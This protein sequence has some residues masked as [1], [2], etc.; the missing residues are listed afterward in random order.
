MDDIKF[1]LED[2]NISIDG[3]INLSD[4]EFKLTKTA[5]AKKKTIFKQKPKF[6]QRSSVQNQSRPTPILRQPTAPPPAFMDKTFEAFSNPQKRM[7]QQD[8]AVS[9]NA[10][11]N[12]DGES[13]AG[14]SAA[15][16][17]DFPQE[18][19]PD[20]TG[21]QPSAGFNSI[22]D[23][24][25]DLL[26]RFHRLES[27]GIKLPKKYNMYSDVREM[28]SDFERIKR[29][30][31]VNA[32]VKFSRRMLTA[33]VSASEFLNKRYDP[34]GL[35]LNGWSETVMENSTDG[36]YD[37]VFER[38]HDKYAGKVNTPPELELMLSL[39]GSAIMF[40]MTSTMFKSIPNLGAMA[41]NNPEMQQAMSNLAQN[42]M[43]QQTATTTTENEQET[44]SQSGRRK[45]RG[46]SM[47]LSSMG[48]MM[49]PPMPSSSFQQQTPNVP[50]SVMSDDDT[51]SQVSNLSVKQV[52]VTAGGTR[53]GRKPKIIANK[54]NS[55]DI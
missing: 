38:L 6:T 55:I 29:D 16:G 2:D 13:E 27:K 39:A 19:M 43:K 22:E 34:F 12:N 53:R 51:M 4:D 45:M 1:S 21:P 17:D 18:D 36:D 25:Q 50:E 32:S 54:E 44:F 7:A 31:E 49:A 10:E 20:N 33:V 3:S 11:S 48:N 42:M 47:N 35:E 24:K 40:H 46:P 26:Y 23:E 5:K 52:S 30:H 37:N 14:E 9:E 41:Q 15:Y 28:R 8:D